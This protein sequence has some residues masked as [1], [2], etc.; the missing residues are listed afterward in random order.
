[1][2]ARGVHGDEMFESDP[3]LA[4]F[5]QDL[6]AAA[7]TTPPPVVGMSLAAVLEG[8]APAPV[9][10]DLPR[11]HAARRS[12]RARWAIGTAVFGLGMGS[13]GVA[14]ALPG[15]VQRQVA[16]VADVVGLNLPDGVP[17]TVPSA[18]TTRDPI[19]DDPSVRGEDAPGD[20]DQGGDPN[21]D[22]G[23]G[24]DE[25]TT[26]PTEPDGVKTTEP[27]STPD[28]SRDPQEQDFDSLDDGPI[29]S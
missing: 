18:P 11:V 24:G 3:Q 8:R 10:A 14:G 17:A 26:E 13:L 7:A 29:E 4:A 25:T 16:R 22:E 6:Q 23:D 1:M 20:T 5:A 9:P 15:P 21:G 12:R 19:T 2:T 27:D 28:Q